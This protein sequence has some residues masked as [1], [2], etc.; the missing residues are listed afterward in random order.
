MML[1][2]TQSILPCPQILKSSQPPAR[3]VGGVSC[4]KCEA[5]EVASPTTCQ[6]LSENLQ[7]PYLGTQDSQQGP[8]ILLQ[9]TW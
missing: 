6:I 3:P 8:W 2:Y 7:S 1:G 5:S 9:T 4:P